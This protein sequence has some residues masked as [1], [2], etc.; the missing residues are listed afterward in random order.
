MRRAPIQLD[1]F[2]L[3]DAAARTSAVA[4]PIAG[5][6]RKRATVVGWHGM[7]PAAIEVDW[8]LID[9]LGGNAVKV[10]VDARSP[11]RKARLRTGDYIVSISPSPTDGMSLADFDA[12][13]DYV[14]TDNAGFTST[15]TRTVI[16]EAATGATSTQ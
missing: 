14:A 7:T 4:T 10:V 8:G 5:A 6:R 9:E 12:P 13:I 2:L 11:A 3:S 1:F 15:S 16:I